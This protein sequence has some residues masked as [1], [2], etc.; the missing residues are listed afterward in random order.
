MQP[1]HATSNCSQRIQWNAEGFGSVKIHGGCLCGAMRYEVDGPL[2]NVGNCHCSMCRRFHGA[3]FASYATVS[4]ENFR[5]LTGQDL[6]TVYESSPGM[7]WAFCRVCGSSLGLP[8]R[9]KLSA[10]ALGT[11]DKDPGVRPTYHMFV[12]TKATWYDITD[13]LPQYDAW[14]PGKAQ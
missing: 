12:G 1:K 5:S 3:A 6:L 7:G 2:T 4:A 11:L 10:L 13:T 9:G 8:S 14:P